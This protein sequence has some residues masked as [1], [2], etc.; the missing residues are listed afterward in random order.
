MGKARLRKK[1]SGYQKQLRKHIAKFKEA[2]ARGAIESMDYMAKEMA[3]F[4][5]RKDALEYRT[6][7]KQTRKRQKKKPS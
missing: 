2:E 4:L 6:L 1:L 5:K 3:S 7:P